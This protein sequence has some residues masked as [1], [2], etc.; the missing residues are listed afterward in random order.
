TTAV[1]E[2][3]A[4]QLIV[5]GGC[6]GSC[7]PALPDVFVLTNANGL[8]G[9]PV[10]SQSSPTSSIPRDNHTA[11][12]DPTTNSMI[13]FGGSLAFFGTDKNDTNVIFPANGSSPTWTTLSPS[14]GLPSVRETA[15]AVYD[16]SHNRMII[17]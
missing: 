4:N 17:F 8:G 1:Y 9:T 5:Y 2:P 12:Y 6:G 10:W 16:I 3:P 15:S 13:T 14:G 7:S 11:V